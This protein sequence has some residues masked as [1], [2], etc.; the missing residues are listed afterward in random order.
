[1]LLGASGKQQNEEFNLNAVTDDHTSSGLRHDRWLRGLTEATINRDW[2]TLADIR[3]QAEA[4]MGLQQVVDT[5]TVAAAFNGITRVADATGI[6]LDEST[7]QITHNMRQATGIEAF[8]YD[9]KS[10]RYG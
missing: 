3:P 7:A 5:L 10:Q 4:E 1:M 2:L 6:P 8:N 9:N